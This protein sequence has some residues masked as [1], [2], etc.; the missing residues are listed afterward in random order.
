MTLCVL[1]RTWRTLPYNPSVLMSRVVVALLDQSAYED[2]ASWAL[3]RSL[4]A[5]VSTFETRRFDELHHVSQQ[6][7][8]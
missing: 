8:N 5:C 7:F 1:L 3:L 6:T 2:R 4:Y